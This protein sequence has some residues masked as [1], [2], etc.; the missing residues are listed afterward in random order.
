MPEH[1]PPNRQSPTTKRQSPHRTVSGKLLLA[2]SAVGCVALFF[3]VW[4]SVRSVEHHIHDNRPALEWSNRAEWIAPAVIKTTLVKPN[5]AN[6]QYTYNKP[7]YRDP[8]FVISPDEERAV[9]A[10]AELATPGSQTSFTDDI[11]RQALLQHAENQ[12]NFYTQYLLATWHQLNGDTS[13]A[14]DFYQQAVTDTPKIIVIQYTDPEGNPAAGLK[15]GIIEI[16]CDRVIDEG[17]ALDQHL[18][19][20][21]PS[22]ETDTAGRVYLPVYNTTY[23]PV[24]LPQVNGYEITYEHPEGWFKLPTRLGTLTATVRSE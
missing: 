10:C 2:G 20:V 3:I 22:Q 21:Y 23:R 6:V 14:D 4:V 15:L 9:F 18:V 13:T 5:A 12:D 16:G 11:T 19:L 7:R 1:D 24:F 17:Q 8:E